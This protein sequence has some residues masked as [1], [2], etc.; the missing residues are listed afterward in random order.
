MLIHHSPPH[1][2]PP[3]NAISLNWLSFLL[4]SL[5]PHQQH[6]SGGGNAELCAFARLFPLSHA[7][8]RSFISITQIA[9]ILNRDFARKADCSFNLLPRA[10]AA[11][12]AVR[13]TKATTQSAI[14]AFFYFS[15]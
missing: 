13:I 7:S 12:G 11:C 3:T 9:A 4:A 15:R 10:E 1:P 14:D 8:A 6:S 2:P 5:A